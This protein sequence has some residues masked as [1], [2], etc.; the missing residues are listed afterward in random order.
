MLS[1][2]L[3]APNYPVRQIVID[4]WDKVDKEYN[5]NLKQNSLS[6]HAIHTE[7]I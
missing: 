7:K 6:I 1:A 3:I 2:Q 5:W 4:S